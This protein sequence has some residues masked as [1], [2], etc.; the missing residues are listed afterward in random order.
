MLNIHDSI[1]GN[2][3]FAVSNPISIPKGATE[4]PDGTYQIVHVPTALV[5]AAPRA[6]ISIPQFKTHFTLVELTAIVES[7]DTGAKITWA[8]LEDPR[9]TEVHLDLPLII[10]G[11]THLETIGCIGPGRAAEILDS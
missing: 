9:I 1:T 5:V 7:E 10:E 6:P 3:L 4:M 11:I 2:F 8:N